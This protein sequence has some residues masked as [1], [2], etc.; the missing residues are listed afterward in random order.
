VIGGLEL[1]TPTEAI[2]AESSARR[3]L[4]PHLK[5]SGIPVVWLP[6]LSEKVGHAQLISVTDDGFQAATDPRAEDRPR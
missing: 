5:D 3:Q 6:D 1:G 2:F 4:E